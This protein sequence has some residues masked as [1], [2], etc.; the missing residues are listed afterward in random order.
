MAKG[1]QAN[2]QRIQIN[3]TIQVFETSNR[4]VEIRLQG[5]FPSLF[6]PT[7]LQVRS[8]KIDSGKAGRLLKQS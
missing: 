1:P 3:L 5:R 7:N 6:K 8:I 2:T 4:G